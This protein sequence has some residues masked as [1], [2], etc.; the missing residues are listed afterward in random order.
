MRVFRHH[1]SVLRVVSF[2]V[3]FHRANHSHVPLSGCRRAAL[4][5]LESQTPARKN[6]AQ[7]IEPFRHGH[8]P[9]K[10]GRQESQ[11]LLEWEPGAWPPKVLRRKPLTSTIHTV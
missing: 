3:L 7:L 2:T 9:L 11:R 5:L 10:R 8:C 1:P 4:G 6:A